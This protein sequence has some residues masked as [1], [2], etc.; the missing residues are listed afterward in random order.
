MALK[1]SSFIWFSNLLTL[2]VPDEGYAWQS[3]GELLL[4]IN[5]CIHNCF[6]YCC[7]GSECIRFLLFYLYLYSHCIS[8]GQVWYIYVSF[9]F[10]DAKVPVKLILYN[11]WLWNRLLSGFIHLKKKYS[12]THR[13]GQYTFLKVD[14]SDSN[15]F[16]S[17]WL[18]YFMNMFYCYLLTNALSYQ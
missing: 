3:S 14:K 17:Q 4:D 1:V 10:T 8:N 13:Q 7:P 16:Q 15:L 12:P 11:Y 2:S 6:C 9:Y 5:D 18:F